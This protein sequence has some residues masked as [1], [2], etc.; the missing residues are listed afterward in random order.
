MKSYYDYADEDYKFLKSVYQTGGV[1]NSMCSIS[2]QTCERYLKYII[3]EYYN[4]QNEIESNNVS[5]VMKAHNLKKLVKFLREDMGVEIPED[6]NNDLNQIN[7]YY[8]ETKYPGDESF[9]A[10]K[11][12]VDYAV[13][14]IDSCKKF[15]DNFIFNKNLEE[16]QTLKPKSGKGL[17]DPKRD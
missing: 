17:N 3:A 13:K 4:P 8:F 6:L 15:V 14:A 11:K 5:D 2:Q 1:W 12:E 7:G 16:M 10:G 9:F